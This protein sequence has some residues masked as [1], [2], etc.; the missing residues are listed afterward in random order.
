MVGSATYRYQCIVAQPNNLQM[1]CASVGKKQIL[2]CNTLVL[3]FGNLDDSRCFCIGSGN[4][5]RLFLCCYGTRWYQFM[6]VFDAVGTGSVSLGARLV[7]GRVAGQQDVS[8]DCVSL[9][10]DLVVSSSG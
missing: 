4:T 10:Y 6:V 3:N 8:Q 2:P 1:I 9:G 5:K 7:S